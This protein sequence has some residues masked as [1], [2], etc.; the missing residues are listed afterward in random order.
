[1]NKETT[2]SR[3][4]MVAEALSLDRIPIYP[5]FNKSSIYLYKKDFS[6]D[7]WIKLY[8]NHRILMQMFELI[9][10]KDDYGPN[11]TNFRRINNGNLFDRIEID[12]KEIIFK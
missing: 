11:I 8:E 3:E 1:M 4:S 10:V 2:I 12:K 6:E 5:D 7:E 9:G